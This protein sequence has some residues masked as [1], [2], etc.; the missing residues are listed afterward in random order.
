M[1]IDVVCMNC[2]QGSDHCKM[3]IGLDMFSADYVFGPR[4]HRSSRIGH[5]LGEEEC[6]WFGHDKR[7]FEVPGLPLCRVGERV[8]SRGERRTGFKGEI[9]ERH[10]W[11]WEDV[12]RWAHRKGRKE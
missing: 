12:V 6:T 4:V 3:D 10:G 5:P 7:E 2:A 11:Q 9:E 8:Y 1:D